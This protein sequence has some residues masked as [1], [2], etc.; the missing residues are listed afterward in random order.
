MLEWHSS[1]KVIEPRRESVLLP[2]LVNRVTT[3]EQDSISGPNKAWIWAKQN[4]PCLEYNYRPCK[5]DLRAPGYVFWDR[6]RL[7]KKMRFMDEACPAMGG[8]SAED[9]WWYRQSEEP[10]AEQRLRNMGYR[11]SCNYNLECEF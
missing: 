4:N 10:S 11:L 3:F 5:R 1:A 7:E 2:Q 9:L 8:V 6:D